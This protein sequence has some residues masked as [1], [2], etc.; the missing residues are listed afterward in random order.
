MRA[1]PSWAWYGFDIGNSAH[2]LMISTVGFALYFREYLLADKPNVDS[3]WGILTALI[4]GFAAL[5]SPIVSS[6]FSH[7]NRRGLGLFVITI[8]CVIAT[9]CLWLPIPI[10]A[11]WIVIGI[12]MI[13]AL[14][15]YIAL[16]L[17]NSFLP[18]VAQ[19]KIQQVSARGWGLGY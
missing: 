18:D 11:S 10:E 3:L 16:P 5:I 12:Y 19:G 9:A 1:K 8:V 2:A 14:G 13:S 17:Y 6:Y 4:L 15:Y 7:I